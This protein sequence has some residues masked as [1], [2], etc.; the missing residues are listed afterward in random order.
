[1]RRTTRRSSKKF[2]ADHAA[3]SDASSSTSMMNDMIIDSSYSDT[4]VMVHNAVSSYF[5]EPVYEAGGVY[6]RD[7]SPSVVANVTTATSTTQRQM[8]DVDNYISNCQKF[9][10]KI[11]PNVVIALQ[12]G[13]NV[14][15]PTK[16]AFDD[17]SMLPL[18]EILEESKN[19]TKV[20]LSD[21]SMQIYNYPGNGNSNARALMQILK[22]NNSIIDLNLSNT[23]LDDDGIKEIS[24]G[25]KTNKTLEYLNLSRNHFGEIGAQH[26][27]EALQVNKTIKRI[28]LSQN[29]L[30]FRSINSLLCACDRKNTQLVTNGNYVFEEILNSVSHGIAFLGSMVGANIMITDALEV[31]KT[32]YHFWACVLYSFSVMFLFL[33]SCLFHS[34]FMIPTS[35]CYYTLSIF[36]QS[37]SS[38]S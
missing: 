19:I 21:V 4:T 26:L 24:D 5:E 6:S 27:T 32:S 30:G 29:A 1:M 17:G 38:S 36:M 14:L 18:M 20:N 12:T 10:L 7:N 11:D 25:I 28:D 33:S 3:E 37:S 34:F 13:W 15:R 35:K 23:G 9:G 2:S 31:Y 16:S 22:K 8:N